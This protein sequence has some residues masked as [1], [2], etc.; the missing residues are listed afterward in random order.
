MISILVPVYNVGDYLSRCLDSILGQTFKDFEI[1]IVND[2]SK[3]HSQKIAQKYAERHD[4]IRLYNY[5]N[6]GIST[7]RNRLLEHASGDYVMFV[8]SDDYIHPKTLE[9]MMNIMIQRDC[10]IVCCGYSMDYRLGSFYRKVETKPVLSKMEA[11]RSLAE[12]KGMNNYPWAKLFKK[13]CFD[14]VRFPESLRGFEDTYTIFKAINNAARIGCTPKRFYH[15]V[16]HAGSLTHHMD[17]EE[18]YDMRRA[19]EYQENYLHRLYPEEN[20]KY[21]T[22]LVNSDFVILYTIFMYYTKKERPKYTPCSVNWKNVNPFTHLAYEL[23]KNLCAV[24][25]GWSKKSAQEFNEWL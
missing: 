21:D 23:F 3:D 4:C 7:T 10:D 19:Y 20:F 24:R 13:S 6:A 22:H 14:N 8:D 18:A 2:G 16:Q 25:Y 12:N 15:Y 11:L 9:T 5:K 1:V 17:L